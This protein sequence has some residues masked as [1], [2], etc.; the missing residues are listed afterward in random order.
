MVDED[1]LVSEANQKTKCKK[2]KNGC[3]EKVKESFIVCV[4]SLFCT[5]SARKF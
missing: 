4:L 5:A 3:K 2:C 1:G